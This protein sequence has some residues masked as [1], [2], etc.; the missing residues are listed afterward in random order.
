[1]IISLGRWRHLVRPEKLRQTV[2]A[3]AVHAGPPSSTLQQSTQNHRKSLSA[4]AIHSDPYR[5][6]YGI[7]RRPNFGSLLC[8]KK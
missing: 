6:W 5:T 4:T 7:I 8:T 2:K 1:M 3:G